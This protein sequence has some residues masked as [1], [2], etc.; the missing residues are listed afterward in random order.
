VHT[1]KIDR[2]DDAQFLLGLALQGRA[3]LSLLEA[4]GSNSIRIAVGVVGDTPLVVFATYDVPP[5]TEDPIIAKSMGP[6]EP[7]TGIFVDLR[8]LEAARQ[9]PKSF[10]KIFRERP[11]SPSIDAKVASVLADS[12]ALK[13]LADLGFEESAID[14]LVDDFLSMQCRVDP[15]SMRERL[16]KQWQAQH[17]SPGEL[18]IAAAMEGAVDTYLT[19]RAARPYA[20]SWLS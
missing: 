12:P 1:W 14:A 20:H 8:V 11:S 7:A 6:Y 9:S 15:L 19:E 4:R 2:L 3:R 5:N 17:S 13:R 16:K 18:C 10:F